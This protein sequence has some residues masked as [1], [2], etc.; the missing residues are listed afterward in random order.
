[1]MH[2]VGSLRLRAKKTDC[3]ADQQSA[4]ARKTEFANPSTLRFADPPSTFSPLVQELQ[5]A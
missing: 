2:D 5:N 4:F 1:M 3:R